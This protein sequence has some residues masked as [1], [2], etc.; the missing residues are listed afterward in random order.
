MRWLI[1][2][3]LI[4]AVI[5]LNALVLFLEAFSAIRSAAQGMLLAVDAACVVYFILEAILKMR[6]QGIRG[7]FADSWNTFD[8]A[9]VVVSLPSLIS[10]APALFTLLR[11]LRLLRFLRLMRF[12]PNIDRLMVG[13]KRALKASIGIFMLVFCYLFI[14]GLSAHYMF[15]YQTE[16]LADG[17]TAYL[18]PDFRD[19]LLSMYTMFKIFTIEG[20]YEMSD[21]IASHSTGITAHL[22]RLYFIFAVS[23]GGIVILSLLNAVFVDEMSHDIAARTE[24]EVEEISEEV[25]EIDTR[26]ETV[27]A[28]ML[29]KLEEISERLER[30]EGKVE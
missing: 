25:E 24:E 29:A 19:P 1:N 18:Y 26:I 7:Y 27:S 15:G 28:K 16:Q 12:I 4:I 5:L 14:F 6:Y 23:F 13:G 3:R 30:L 2:E 9:I 17:T 20:W 21:N 22:I 10:G 11:L 8:F